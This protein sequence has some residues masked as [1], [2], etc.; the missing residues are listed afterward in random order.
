[1]LQLN[2]MRISNLFSVGLSPAAADLPTTNSLKVNKHNP[3]YVLY[4]AQLTIDIWYTYLH[5][6]P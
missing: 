1:M 4:S 2:Q 3:L 5:V 6:P